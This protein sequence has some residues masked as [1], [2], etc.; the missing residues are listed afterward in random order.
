MS[1]ARHDPSPVAARPCPGA[2]ATTG[3]LGLGDFPGAFLGAVLAFLNA[4]LADG[5]NAVLDAV[6][7]AVLTASPSATLAVVPV[8]R[9]CP[10]AVPTHPPSGATPY[11]PRGSTRPGAAAPTHPT[12]GHPTG[13]TPRAPRGC[14][15]PRGRLD[16]CCARRDCCASMQLV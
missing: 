4:V 9:T 11:A 10:G 6:L 14:A 1:A 15:A 16:I 5:S 7:E 12:A 2:A 8:G 13:A 3:G